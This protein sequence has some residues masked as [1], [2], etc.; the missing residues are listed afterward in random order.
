MSKPGRLL[1][2]LYRLDSSGGWTSGMRVIAHTLLGGLSLPA[3][4]L[5]DLGC[6]GGV[7]ATELAAQFLPHLATGLDV[8]PTALA[9]ARQRAPAVALVQ[10]DLHHLPFAA[11]TYSLVT[12]LDVLDQRG[13]DT[14]Q[15]MR[16][17]RR[18]LMAGGWLLVRVSAHAWLQGPHDLAFNTGRRYNPAQI[19]HVLFAAGFAVRRITFAN[20]LLSP[21]VIAV[22]LLQRWHLLP[23]RRSLYGDPLT[24]AVLRWAL[25]RE[26][27]RIAVSDLP[28]GISLYAL[29]QISDQ[30]DSHK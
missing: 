13:V 19:A 16:E 4:P 9:Q 1:P 30:S 26:A 15:A 10:A 20:T 18:V 5:L 24:N 25:T 29:A 2:E 28:F 7:F 12:A 11:Q 6:G 27:D 8:E 14:G 3:G 21:A 17:I 23:F 22:R